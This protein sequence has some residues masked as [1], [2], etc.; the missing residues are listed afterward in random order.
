MFYLREP[1]VPFPEKTL[2]SK[3][4][5]VG[6][7]ELTVTV[8]VFVIK[9]VAETDTLYWPGKCYNFQRI[10]VFKMALINFQEFFILYI[11]SS[12]LD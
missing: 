2:N 6:N 9:P 11:K 5:S 8:C 4:N 3:S 7:P 1:L 10:F 12:F